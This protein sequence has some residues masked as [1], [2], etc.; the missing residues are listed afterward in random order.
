MTDSVEKKT[1]S[2]PT[3]PTEAQNESIIDLVEEIEELSPSDPL[4]ALELQLLGIADET[5]PTGQPANDLAKLDP[6]EFNPVDA[7]VG[8]KMESLELD[9]PSSET[10]K[11]AEPGT[12]ALKEMEPL[13]EEDEL[14]LIEI[15]DTEGEDVLG[16][17]DDLDTNQQPA[18]IAPMREAPAPVYPPFVSEPE[19]DP[20]T[21]A[22][23]VFA[24]NM[25]AGWTET[26]RASD[27][28]ALPEAPIP[29][30]LQ[31][32]APIPVL[33]IPSPP[34]ESPTVA[35]VVPTLTDEQVDA[36]VARVIERKMGSTF[37]SIVLRAIETAVSNEIQ[38][39]KTLLL[40]DD[41]GDSNP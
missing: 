22:I 23:D 39:L 28:P 33:P 7:S 32:S 3:E 9:E 5:R 30:D 21:S 1:E 19:A 27:D 8:A 38:R 26:D 29:N 12:F 4:S 14:E 36:A 17:A 10:D 16:Q 18:S 24:A 6:L 2:T 20:A 15:E 34:P 35:E 13:L 25:T 37:E 41:P 31:L 11:I 40:E